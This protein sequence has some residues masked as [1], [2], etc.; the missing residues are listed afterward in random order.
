MAGACNR[1][2]RTVLK[3]VGGRPSPLVLCYGVGVQT[4]PDRNTQ[5]PGACGWDG[6][7]GASWFTD[8]NRNLVSI[9]MTQSSDFLFNGALERYRAAVY[10]AT[11]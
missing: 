9:V 7:F 5:T 2:E 10:A 6:G 3:G 11:A 8:P 4:G 1:G